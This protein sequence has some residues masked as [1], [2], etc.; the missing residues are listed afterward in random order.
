V[1]LPSDFQFSQ[2][3]LQDYVDCPRRFYLRYVR[4]LAWPAVLAEPVLEHERHLQQGI[5]FHLL[6]HQ[7][8]LGLPEE[9]LTR[10]AMAEDLSRWWRNYLERHPSELPERQYYEFVLS[11]P[12]EGYRLVAKYDLV[13]VEPGERAVIVDWKTYR[14]RRSGD[15]LAARLQT[16]LYPYL[17]VQAG[18]HLNEGR[19]IEPGHV[20]MLYWFANFPDEPQRFAYT[21]AQHE[22]DGEYLTRLIEEITRLA[23]EDFELTSDEKQCQYCLYRSLCRRG[24]EAGAFEERDEEGEAEERLDIPLDWDQIAEVEY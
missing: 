13:A 7:R 3:V 23:D 14:R 9:R 16:R 1:K 2:S 21:Q 22:A 20:E 11:A 17:L 6:V 15:W 19:A 4:R 8:A 24:V 12:L 18:A 10:T 5:D